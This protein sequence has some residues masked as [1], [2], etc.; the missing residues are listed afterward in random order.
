MVCFGPKSVTRL[1]LSASVDLQF[2]GVANADARL[3]DDARLFAGGHFRPSRALAGGPWLHA[4]FANGRPAKKVVAT[5]AAALGAAGPFQSAS[6]RGHVLPASPARGTIRTAECEPGTE[7]LAA[8]AVYF[9]TSSAAEAPTVR[10]TSTTRRR[11]GSTHPAAEVLTT[12]HTSTTRQHQRGSMHPAAEASRTRHTSTAPQRCGSMH[13]VAEAS[14]TRHMSTGLL[15]S[16]PATIGE[17]SP[18]VLS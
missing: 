5:V 12:R 4:R 8:R 9:S 15:T 14:T 6:Q 18:A 1:R 2:A 11:H 10:H 7:V 13:P 3:A 16:E 17:V